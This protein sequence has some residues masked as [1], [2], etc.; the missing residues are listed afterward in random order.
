MDK[1]LVIGYIWPEP[2][3]T[4]AGY[5]LLQ[6]IDLFIDQGYTI[7]FCSAARIKSTSKES[8][9]ERDIALIPISLNDDSLDRVLEK[10]LP[11][12]VLYDRFL[13]E[14]QYG[15]RVR[16]VLPDALQILD[17]EDLHFLRAARENMALNKVTLEQGFENEIAMREISSMRRVDLSIIISSYEIKLLQDQFSMRMDQ[18]FYLPFLIEH[19]ELD[20]RNKKAVPY[21]NR[22]DYC[23]IGNLRHAPNVDS[24]EVLQREIWP[25]IKEQQSDAVL[26]IYGPNAPKKILELHDPPSGFLIK[27]H[28]A[29]V[30]TALSKHR[31][32]LAPLRYGA[33]LKGKVFD[34]MKNGLPIVG[35]AIAFEGIRENLAVDAPVNFANNAIEIYNNPMLWKHQVSGNFEVLKTDFDK[36]AFAEAFYSKI[37]DLITSRGTFKSLVD[38]IALYHADKQFKYLNYWINEKKKNS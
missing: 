2:Q 33:G 3:K 32:L 23:T 19:N 17:T 7:I 5:R 9:L 31:V 36:H 20:H 21:S 24:I 25:Q 1:L 38:K 15:W 29:H 34:A 8:L 18:L 28:A 12:I 10:E 11:Q 37:N 22:V 26:H 16:Q 6:I 30:D 27:G 35:T 14:E 4:A 13:I